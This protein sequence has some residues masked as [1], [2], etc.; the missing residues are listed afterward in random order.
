M[1]LGLMGG[2]R[3]DTGSGN[4]NKEFL[5][6]MR[7]QTLLQLVHYFSERLVFVEPG[8]KFDDCLAYPHRASPKM[9]RNVLNPLARQSPC[10]IGYQPSATSPLP[11]IGL[12]IDQKIDP[13]AGWPES[14]S[15]VKKLGWEKK[16][17]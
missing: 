10:Q 9:L 17:T 11:F 16:K 5:L 7:A 3:D 8:L 2:N 6:G 15:C 13:R 4:C 14:F 1:V 12:G